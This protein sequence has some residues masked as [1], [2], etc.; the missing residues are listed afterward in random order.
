M[1]AALTAAILLAA[2]PS[3]GAVTAKDAWVRATVPT[4]QSTGAFL[5]LQAS[6]DSRLVGVQ[7][8]I[9]KSAELHESSHAGSVMHMHAVDA[10][11]LP[12]GKTVQLK[13]GGYHLMLF[14][15]AKPLKVGERVPLV[16][17]IEHRDGK[18][19]AVAIMA[20]VRAL[21]R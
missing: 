17:T 9:A 20:E 16:L 5:T 11:A 6:E 2:L 12:A 19:S 21:A 3:F 1:R 7:T 18:R 8:S 4:Q 14:G 13:P 15:L 10:I